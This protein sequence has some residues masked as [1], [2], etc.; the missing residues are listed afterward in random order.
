MPQS[1]RDFIKFVVAGS[2]AAGCPIDAALIPAP[3]SNTPSSHPESAP[4]VDGEHFEVCHQIRDGR[5]FHLPSATS[6]VAIV[7]V[8]GGVAGLSAAYF[9]RG[10]D[11]LLLEKEPHF[12]GNAY[13]EEFEGQPFAT[14]AAYAYR[15]DEGDQLASEIGLKLPLVNMPDPTLVNKTYVP[16]TWKT[17]ISQLPYPKEVVATFQKFRDDTLKLNVNQRMGE[18]DA[19]PFSQF[20][21]A[22][23]PEVQQWWDI[24]GPSN[25]GAATHDTSAYVGLSNAQDLFTG[26]DAK[27]AILPGGLGCITHK[28]VKLLQPKYKDRMLDDATVVAVVQKKDVVNVTY[29]R[30]GNLATVS[31]KAVLMCTPKQITSRIV[32]SLPAEQQA[33]MQRTRYAPYPVVN[34]IFDKPVYNRGY[35]NWCPG[36]SFTDFIVADW[37]IRN[38][39]GYKQKDNI[40]TFYTPLREAQRS[41][42]LDINDCK[43]LAARVLSDFQK[44]LPEFN[45]DPVEVRIYRRGHPMFMATPGQYTKN[46]IVAAQPMDRIYFGNSDSGGPES[47]TSEAVRL[48]HVGAEW[49]SLVLAGKPGAKELAEKALAAVTD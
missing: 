25:W 23:A 36:N 16:D 22:Y 33:A 6:K 49:A 27:R 29:L 26:G 24:F 4:L 47:L 17:G 44:I 43:T 41:T 34:A 14:G 5:H 38:N 46:R 31:A 19:L 39:P 15:G 1:R 7:I 35:D 13:Q 11:W 20:T 37:T 10:E 28:L 45:V 8:G 40:L 32:L 9:L 42:L 2:V 48:S 30:E 18:L 3:D 21:S 12:G